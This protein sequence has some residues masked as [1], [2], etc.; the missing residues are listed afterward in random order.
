MDLEEAK[1]WLRDRVDDGER[2]PCCGQ[3]AKVYKRRMTAFTARAMIAMYR[4]HRDDYVQMPDLIRR[5]LPN[6]TQGGYATLGLYWQ[7]IEEEK[8]RRPD[9]GRAG[10][11]K[12][13]EDGVRFVRGELTVP[14]YA[15]IYDSRLLSYEG[16]MISIRETLGT[17]FDYDALMRGDA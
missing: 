3:L 1:A 8:Q 5:H 2:C 17:N 16:D 13:T 10:W 4:H 11:W 7:L 9:G 14:R 6:Q 15:R 12:L